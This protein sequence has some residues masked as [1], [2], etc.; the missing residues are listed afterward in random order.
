M[1]LDYMKS[2]E[3]PPLSEVE[4]LIERNT[5]EITHCLKQIINFQEEK[6]KLY[7]KFIDNTKQNRE[8]E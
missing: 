3:K 8:N 1:K 2:I 5:Q 6:L 4:E 7:Q